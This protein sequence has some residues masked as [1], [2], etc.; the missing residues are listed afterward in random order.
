MTRLP[1]PPPAQ[2]PFRSLR[3]TVLLHPSITNMCTTISLR[4]SPLT[5]H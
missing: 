4:I 2:S 3:H 5:T 1:H